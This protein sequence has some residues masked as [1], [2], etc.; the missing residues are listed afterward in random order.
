MAY[1]PGS[2]VSVMVYT[3]AMPETELVN[4][5]RTDLL[6]A[7]KARDQLTTTTLQAILSAIDNAGT[8]PVPDNINT[9][10]T[11]STEVPRRELSIRDMHEL[12]AQE[13]TEI[14]HTIKELG[15]KQKSYVDELRKRIVILENYL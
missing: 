15:D 9:I 11:G 4:Q 12:V 3:K 5:I 2:T 1:S 10:G 7:R 13:I 6:K 8:I 14:Q